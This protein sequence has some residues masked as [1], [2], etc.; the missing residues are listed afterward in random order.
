MGAGLSEEQCCSCRAC[1]RQAPTW[2]R[3]DAKFSDSDSDGESPESAF[4]E[5]SARLDASSASTG[6]VSL[7]ASLG[8]ALPT[9]TVSTPTR[10][11]QP[12]R[13]NMPKSSADKPT[14]WPNLGIPAVAQASHVALPADAVLRHHSSAPLTR[15]SSAP[16]EA[17]AVPPAAPDGNAMSPKYVGASPLDRRSHDLKSGRAVQQ[18]SFKARGSSGQ[19]RSR[20][21]SGFS[22]AESCA[23]VRPTSPVPPLSIGSW[24]PRSRVGSMDVVAGDNGSRPPTGRA[25]S[26]LLR[27]PWE[28]VDPG[29][30]FH[31]KPKAGLSADDW[32]P[33]DLQEHV[34]QDGTPERLVSY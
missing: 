30:P 1:D 26:P 12:P 5:K 27:A 20:L 16:A 6:A 10:G 13:L 19:P 4:A 11:L 25:G 24:L 34:M 18:A 9:S 33:P 15:A 22:A 32:Q 28:E 31:M 14:V 2:Q 23:T 7:N 8:V 17:K 29:P 21:Q 3:W